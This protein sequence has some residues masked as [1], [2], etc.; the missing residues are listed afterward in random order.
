MKHQLISCLASAALAVGTASAAAPQAEYLDRGVVAVGTTEGVFVSWRSLVTD[1]ADTSFDIYRNGT[2]INDQPIST[3]TNYLDA[4]G[5]AGATYEVRATNTTVAAT[6]QAQAWAEPYMKVHLDRPEGGKVDGHSYTFSPDDISVGDVDGDGVYELFVKWVPS[7]A[8]DSASGGFTGPTIIDCYK[9]DGTRLWR[10]DLGHNI[11][12]GNHYTQFMVYDFDGDGSAE[13]ICKTAPGTKDGKGNWV[14][15]EGDK[16]TDDY[17]LYDVGDRKAAA[18]G[19]VF[20]GAEYLTCFSGKTGEA[21]ST[22]AYKPGY[23][24]VSEST[25]GDNYANRSDRYLAG[26]AYLDGLHPSA[27]MCRGYYRCAFVWA[28]D[29]KDG[30]LQEVWFHESKEKNK[31]LWGEGAH[32]LTIGDVD[33]DGKDEIVYGAASLDHD[34]T[35]LYR[36]NKFNVGEGHGDALH[37]ARMIPDREGYQVFMPHESKDAGYAFDTEMRDAR[38]G[39][40]IFM[41]PQSGKDI[42]RGL[43]ANV[44]P[45]YPGYEYWAAS[46]AN[47]YSQGQAISTN[48]PSINF[49]IY[50]DGDLLDECLDGTSITKP[51]PDF[52]KINELAQFSVYSNAAACNGTKNTPNLQADLFGDWREEVIL[53]DGATQS[54]LLIFT[55]T[56][57]TVYKIP[58]LMQDHHYRMAIAWQNTAYNQPPHPSFCPEDV[59]DTRAAILL[60]SGSASQMVALGESIE[61]VT[62]KA[63]NAAGLAVG[64]LPEGLVWNYDEAAKAGTLSGKPAA[65]G[66]YT[67][68]VTTTGA[69]NGEEAK[70]QIKIK[71]NHVVV[72]KPLAYYSFDNPGATV[73]NHVYGQA[74]ATGDAPEA[75]QGKK[76][77]AAL[78]NGSNHYTQEAYGD[79]Q[80]GSRDFTVEMWMKSADDAAYVFHKG[81]HAANA[82]TGATGHWIGLELKNAVLYFAID[83]NVTKSQAYMKEADKVF[84]NEWHHVVLVRDTYK[85]QL[86]MYIDGELKATGADNTGAIS[87]NNELFVMGNV[88][89]N[90]DNAFAGALDE[91]TIF[92]GAMSAEKVAERYATT[93]KEL[94]Y[95]PFDE[96]GETTPNLVFGSAAAAGGTPSSAAG[97]KAGAASFADGSHFRQDAYDA[98]QMGENDFTVECWINST[99]TD[100]YLFFKGSHSANSAAG[101]TGHWIGIERHSNGALNFSIDD[102]VTKTETKLADANYVFDGKWHHIACVRDFANKTDY[103]YVDGVEKAKTTAVKTGAIND[104]NE[105]MLIGISDETARPYDGLMDEL[106]IH[107]R[108]LSADEVLASY[109]SLAQSNIQEVIATSENA[110]YTVVDAFSGITVRRAKGAD[111]S[112][113]TNG[114]AHGVYVLVIETPGAEMETYKFVK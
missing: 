95:F 20:G 103:L 12:S 97:L 14:L 101:T 54:D 2:K 50:W 89:V 52:S 57:P 11:R 25:W 60:S 100:G 78:F 28:V 9:L 44:S 56:I 86:Y 37:L 114:L 27:I 93:G 46:D 23:D 110:V 69:A 81:S 85:K 41:K 70:M 31:G 112:S 33:F 63:R 36:T 6:G 107:P 76:G 42:G 59:Y 22:I 61:D 72:L 49:R 68:T 92:E 104:N 98:I 53:H 94:A 62:V 18:R 15:M 73:A 82:E 34:G 24:Y 19:H 13:M 17:R 91:F 39:E 102:N 105:P 90:Y 67:V 1:A 99:D 84:D 87:D 38:T 66:D 21:L 75:V 5:Q 80:L 26:V 30:K 7:D 111:A 45:D 65:E 10:V 88:G 40:I 96:V 113:I 55:T 43:A 64:E 51:T 8:K 108:A 48:R 83:D 106:V 58:T 29:F 4:A 32:S 47:V 3:K 35:L 16:E 71:V 74:T 109:T 77:N 79:I